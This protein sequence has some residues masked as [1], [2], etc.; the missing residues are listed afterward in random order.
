MNDPV[1]LETYDPAGLSAITGYSDLHYQQ[2]E[3]S[4]GGTYRFSPALYMTAQ[5]SWA[6]F[7][8]K[9][10]YVYGDLSGDAYRGYLG[11]GYRF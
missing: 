8:D 2:T 7:N 5:A 9:D 10:D 11:L 3:I 1:L 4:L 6:Y